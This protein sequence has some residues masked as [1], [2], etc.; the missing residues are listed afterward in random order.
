MPAVQNIYRE[1]RF[2]A[3]K[4]GFY[5]DILTFQ[6]VFTLMLRT[7]R[8]KR[9]LLRVKILLK[10]RTEDAFCPCTQAGYQTWQIGRLFRPLTVASI[11][12]HGKINAA[13]LLMAPFV[14]FNSVT[15]SKNFMNIF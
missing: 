5:S 10:L 15:I 14:L 8:T 4:N 3:S 12:E 13:K 7:H 11:D 1:A 6:W 2:E 9:K